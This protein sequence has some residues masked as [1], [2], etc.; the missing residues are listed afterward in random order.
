MIRFAKEKSKSSPHRQTEWYIPAA[1]NRGHHV[2]KKNN[3]VILTASAIKGSPARL[4]EVPIKWVS[5]PHVAAAAAAFHFRVRGDSAVVN[6]QSIAQSWWLMLIDDIHLAPHAPEKYL[7]SAINRKGVSWNWKEESILIIMMIMN[8]LLL[9][10]VV[11][12][13][14]PVYVEVHVIL[15]WLILFRTSFTASVTMFWWLYCFSLQE[16]GSLLDVAKGHPWLI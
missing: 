11:K 10:V 12:V 13:V 7:S 14:V 2:C 16:S 4:N 1:A 3:Y 9:V 6:H 5:L 15:L 8:V